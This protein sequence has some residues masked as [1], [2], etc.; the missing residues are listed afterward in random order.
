M[1]L[2]DDRPSVSIKPNG[3]NGGRKTLK[4]TEAIESQ[5]VILKTPGPPQHQ[6][7]RWFFTLPYDS[8]EL[9]SLWQDLRSIAKEFTFQQ[10]KG[11]EDGYLHWQ[12]VF[13]LKT[14]E[15][16]ATVKNL[17]PNQVHLEPCKD[18]HAARKY[19]SKRET[20]I[21]NTYTE[22]SVLLRC[23][24]SLFDWQ[25]NCLDIILKEIKKPN[26]RIIH[27]YWDSKGRSGKTQFSKFLAIRH[28]ALLFNN[29]KTSDIAYAIDGNPEIVVFNFPR[30]L[31]DNVNYGALEMIKDGLIFSAKYESKCKIFNPP[32]VLCFAN[33]KPKLS[34][35]SRD[36]WDV[37]HISQDEES[38]E[39]SVTSKSSLPD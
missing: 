30:S 14:K 10:E 25:E 20:R 24:S 4:A 28:G 12:G 34:K 35:L 5:G 26:D 19:C 29:G 7:Y 36:R 11:E 18:W 38:D 31:E 32:V 13:S 23:I 1:R 6:L 21:G 33:F 22:N 15:Y 39:E 3:A 27:W 17:F 8:I 2:P 9:G 37:Q 16:F